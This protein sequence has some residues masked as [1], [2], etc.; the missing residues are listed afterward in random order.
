[1]TWN[2]EEKG[3]RD[4]TIG[5]A[6]EREKK[7][8]LDEE[9]CRKKRMP[10]FKRQF[11]FGGFPRCAGLEIQIECDDRV[12]LSVYLRSGLKG[13][14]RRRDEAT[15]AGTMVARRRCRRR[16]PMP[17]KMTALA[18]TAL[19]PGVVA[20]V[21]PPALLAAIDAAEKEHGDGSGIAAPGTMPALLPAMLLEPQATRVPLEFLKRKEKWKKPESESESL[22]D[23]VFLRF[24]T[25]QP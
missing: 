5:G 11:Y 12:G 24:S 2:G 3:A 9:R 4:A 13:D 23:S 19:L 17:A 21:V 18:E 15:A 14:P 1:M 8:Q 20:V 16:Q 22:S 6:R 25:S 10:G 7:K